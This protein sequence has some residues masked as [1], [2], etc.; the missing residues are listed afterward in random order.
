MKNSF[1]GVLLLALTIWSTAAFS[2][3]VN[4]TEEIHTLLPSPDVAQMNKFVDIPVSLYTG[5]MNLSV[6][7]YEIKMNHFTIPVALQYNSSGIKVDESASWIGAGWTMT[8]EGA[9][10]RNVNGLPDE[11]LTMAKGL[12]HNTRFFDSNGIRVSDLSECGD[13]LLVTPEFDPESVPDSITMGYLDFEPDVFYLSSPVGN[14]KFVFN[15]NRQ[16]VPY[17]Y[18]DIEIVEHPFSDL[19]NIGTKWV[20]RNP[21]GVMMEF[22]A[23]EFM[24]SNSGCTTDGVNYGSTPRTFTGSRSAWKITKIYQDKEW[25][26]Y[27]YE[28]DSLAVDRLFSETTDFG[29]YGTNTRFKTCLTEVKYFTKYLKKITTSSGITVDFHSSLRADLQGRHKL[30]TVSVVRNGDFEKRMILNND[31]SLTKLRLLSVY[32]VDENGQSLPGYSFEYYGGNMPDVGD[33]GQ[34]YWGYYNGRNNTT[35]IPD[36]ISNFNH[37]ES[38]ADREPVLSSCQVGTIKSVTYPTGGKS[39][40]TYELH[41]Y[42]NLA[43]ECAELYV[44]QTPPGEI[45]SIN[46][47]V[48]ESTYFTWTNAN[49]VDTDFDGGGTQYSIME[50]QK[51]D[52]G[53]Y[54]SYSPATTTGNRFQLDSGA[55][56]IYAENHEIGEDLEMKV[57]YEVACAGTTLVGGL[58]ISKVEYQESGSTVFAKEYEYKDLSGVSSGLLFSRP[59]FS[60]LE[61]SYQAGEDG[62][63][64]EGVDI[65]YFCT[66]TE[67]KNWISVSSSPTVATFSGTHLAYSVV[68]EKISDAQSSNGMILHEFINETIPPYSY[69]PVDYVDKSIV[70]GKSLY[71][72]VLN[73]QLDTL[74][75]SANQY[76]EV[77]SS[78]VAYGVKSVRRHSRHCYDCNGAEFTEDFSASYYQISPKWHRLKETRTYSIEGGDSLEKTQLFTYGTDHTYPEWI[79]NT[80]SIQDTIQNHILRDAQNPGLVVE[81]ISYRKRPS[82]LLKIGQKKWVYQEGLPVEESMWNRQTDLLTREGVIVRDTL[83]NILSYQQ[84]PDNDGMSTVYIRA[85]NGS[86]VVAEIQNVTTTEIDN[87]WTPHTIAGLYT[88]NDN[89]TINLRLESLRQALASTSIPIRIFKYDTN[90]VFGPSEIIDANGQE[91]KYEYDS[92]GRL[93]IIRDHQG[94]A[95]KKF[96]YS[97][98]NQ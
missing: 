96:E 17:E 31:D 63:S 95:L 5:Q 16:I 22:E 69:P 42:D 75:L 72:V 32:Q 6:P 13:P 8:G 80:T 91:T 29:L 74:Q 12:F 11:N 68:K 66:N 73:D 58:R 76:S 23:M 79:E 62:L 38:S 28:D 65:R 59:L 93:T 88:L 50:I 71:N 60:G 85:Y 3:E 33:K 36:Y 2:Q 18:T 54:V 56:R 19:S 37:F 4:F 78:L 49:Y 77:D 40:F 81:S 83:G 24:S 46:F 84:Q 47:S 67:L 57:E 26:T 25:V 10:S 43:K 98:A 1:A 30:D 89:A 41:D 90:D 48:S 55:Y 27:E 70:N 21:S 9:V 15:H 7:I 86:R 20:I 64:N 97:Y 92:F 87:L 61:A 35:L 44:V 82:D 45:D 53:S 34:D 52:N 39:T 51:L 94:H 14:L